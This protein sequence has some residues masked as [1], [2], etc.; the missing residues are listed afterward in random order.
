MDT[1][2]TPPKTPKT[3]K[4]TLRHP[5]HT[6]CSPGTA[7]TT[8]KHTSNILRGIWVVKGCQR[9]LWEKEICQKLPV[10]C[11][12]CLWLSNAALGNFYGMTR[13]L[14][15]SLGIS[16]G[17]LGVSW[18]CLGGVGRCTG[19]SGGC[20]VLISLQFPYILESHKSDPWHFQSD[21]RFRA[22]I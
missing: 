12:K 21:L 8:P 19:G 2:P 7:L 13:V 22:E 6:P 20:L 5:G 16:G 1:P 17:V 9:K 14:S 15:E 11:L 18:G 3:I 4:T 10:E